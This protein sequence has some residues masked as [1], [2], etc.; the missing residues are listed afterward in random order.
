M[1]FSMTYID[2]E[3]GRLSFRL[4]P[5]KVQ[6]FDKLIQIVASALIT[7]EG[8]DVLDPSEGGSLSDILGYN[9]DP[10]DLS[11]LSGEIVRRV[12]KAQEEIINNQIGLDISSEERLRSIDVTY[13]VPGE[14][15]GDVSL[16][17]RVTNEAG[18]TRD[19]VV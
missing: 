4:N 3:T 18:R 8:S 10:D 16:G 2:P 14:V 6:G 19:F 5:K 9:Y 7:K 12:N 17:I 13:L 11:G 15:D 1:D